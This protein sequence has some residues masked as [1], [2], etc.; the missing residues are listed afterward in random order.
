MSDQSDS[1][2]KEFSPTPKKLADARKKGEVPRSADLNT[3][4]SYAGLLLVGGTVG[5]LLLNQ[6]GAIL[7]T[8]LAEAP[9]LAQDIF[10]GGATAQFGVIGASMLTVLAAWFLFPL[11]LVVLSALV[12]RSLVFAPE[13]LQPKISRIN[14]IANAKNKFGRQGLFEFAKSALKLSIFLLV[15]FAFLYGRN[16][17]ILSSI[18][19]A[20]TQVSALLGSISFEFFALV[21]MISLLIGVVDFGWQYAEHIRKNRMTRRELMD[22]TK[23]SEGDPHFKGKRRQRAQE[24]ATKQML[25]EVPNANVVIVN[26]THFATALAWRPT[27]GRAPICVAKG[28]DAVAARI[29][30]IALE[31]NVPIF[32]DPPTAR[33]IHGMVDVGG[34]IHPEHYRAVAA[35][36][37]FADKMRTRAL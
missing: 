24:L 27:D 17:Q 6:L 1:A 37:R 14:P 28:T 21:L 26:P 11:V 18:G 8:L 7:S 20:P 15:L 23:Q 16:S 35:A 3:S 9:P 31:H 2:E 19:L 10:V 30:A 12:Q 32:S 25:S 22:E 4:A 33:A 36:I 5:G 34:E 13:K 29:R